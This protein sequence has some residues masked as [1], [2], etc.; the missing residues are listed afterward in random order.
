MPYAS[1]T[2]GHPG[3]D[4]AI[5]ADSIASST[6]TATDAATGGDHTFTVVAG[7]TYLV[8][9][10]QLSVFGLADVTTATNVRWMCP[11]N[12]AAIVHVP[13]DGGTT[14]HY[15]S[16]VNGGIIYLLRIA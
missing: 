10:T 7:A 8:G 4:G 6:Q 14:L 15:Q 12:Q 11:G 16:A 5:N 2:D 3:V 1:T 9:C 13:I